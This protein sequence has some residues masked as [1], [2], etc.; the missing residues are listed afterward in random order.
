M[1]IFGVVL[2]SVALIFGAKHYID[3]AWDAFRQNDKIEKLEKLLRKDELYKNLKDCEINLSKSKSETA[4]EGGACARKLNDLKYKA[5][6]K[7]EDAKD[8]YKKKKRQIE[9]EAKKRKKQKDN[10]YRKLEDKYNRM[11]K[12]KL[13]VPIIVDKNLK[14]VKPYQFKKIKE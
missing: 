6:R 5:E 9:E 1:N 3:K 12:S 10:R 7:V 11:R 4:K 14:Q 8:E 2:G 13:C